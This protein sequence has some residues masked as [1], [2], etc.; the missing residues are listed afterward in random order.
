MG[1]GMYALPLLQH[2]TNRILLPDMAILYSPYDSPIY[3]RTAEEPGPWS[4]YCGFPASFDN[5]LLPS[6]LRPAL[7]SQSG[8]GSLVRGLLAFQDASCRTHFFYHEIP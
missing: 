7:A 5:L 1:F 2:K 8:G 4:G 6:E 3:S